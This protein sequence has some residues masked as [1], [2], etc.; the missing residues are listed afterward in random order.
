M[1]ANVTEFIIPLLLLFG[2][3]KGF[4]PPAV[5]HPICGP[6]RSVLAAFIVTGPHRV[7]DMALA[8]TCVLIR[9]LKLG[10]KLSASSLFF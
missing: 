5:L 6:F 3:H 2:S 4:V 1:V 9:G 10:A 8:I 7:I